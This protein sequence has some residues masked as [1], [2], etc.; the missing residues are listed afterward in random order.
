MHAKIMK[1]VTEAFIALF[2]S[3]CERELWLY[4]EFTKPD[5]CLTSGCTQQRRSTGYYCSGRELLSENVSDSIRLIS[6]KML[7][8]P[9]AAKRKERLR[10]TAMIVRCDTEIRVY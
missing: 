8:F 2:V 5:I 9:G 10:D 7:G 1:N 3:N 6:L 4:R